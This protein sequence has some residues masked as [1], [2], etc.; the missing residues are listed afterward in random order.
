LLERDVKIN[1]AIMG[2][3]LSPE[4]LDK[5]RSKAR[6]QDDKNEFVIPPFIVKAKKVQFPKIG[7]S[8]GMEMVK[9]EWANRDLEFVNYKENIRS[10]ED[11][12]GSDKDWHEDR[13]ST[14]GKGYDASPALKQNLGGKSKYT[15]Q[16]PGTNLGRVDFN[17]Y[18]DRNSQNFGFDGKNTGMTKHMSKESLEFYGKSSRENVRKPDT[19]QKKSQSKN[20]HLNPI[21]SEQLSQNGAR[22]NDSLDR[23][24]KPFGNQPGNVS[25][26]IAYTPNNLPPMKGKVQLQPLNAPGSN[27]QRS[28]KLS[29]KATLLINNDG[30]NELQNMSSHVKG[31]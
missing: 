6:W 9:E 2:Y 7:P 20:I 30:S 16:T 15:S 14:A 1:N 28:M 25:S 13:I 29:F 12:Y 23:N 5:I 22:V 3:L 11:G 21:S 18:G 10:D 26:V 19:S 17:A 31:C 4:E 24:F 8:Q 27:N